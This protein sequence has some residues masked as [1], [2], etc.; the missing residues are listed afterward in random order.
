M[1]DEKVVGLYGDANK[2]AADP[3]YLDVLQGEI[4]LNRIIFGGGYN[5]SAQTRAL[6]PFTNGPEGAAPGLS[7]TNDDRPLRQAIA[8]CHSRGIQVWGITSTYWAGAEHAPE[9]MAYHL[10][11]QRMDQFPKLPF[12]HEQGS[13]TFCPNNPRINDWFAAVLVEVAV[14]YDFQGYALTHFRYC[15]PAFLPQLMG[16]GCPVCQQK[17]AE[18]GY[19][20]ERMRRAVL[21]VPGVLGK[22]PVKTLHAAACA[23]LGFFDFLQVLGLDGPAIADWLNFR[24]AALTHNLRRFSTAVHQAAPREFAFGSDIHYPSMALLVGQRYADFVAICDQI[25]PLLSHNEIH[26]L[27]NLGSFASHLMQWVDGLGEEDAVSLVYKLFGI[28]IAG[29]PTTIQAMH[30][31]D[32]IHAE[33]EMTALAEVI[34]SEM[35]KARLFAG[36][37]IPSYPVIKGSLWPTATVKRLMAAALETG[38]DGVVLQGTDALFTDRRQPQ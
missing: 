10:S 32:P 38:H 36:P 24:A 16:C 1:P 21:G 23:D 2:I 37:A 6:N 14:Q 22:I 33:L 28:T 11:G 20:F 18:L 25:L 27:D 29:M 19:D 34:T 12:A 30:L 5:L 7:L 15:H 3:G 35:A 31:G 4:G 8:A 9:L 13:M 17:A 26:Y